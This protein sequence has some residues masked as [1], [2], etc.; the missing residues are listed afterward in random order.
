MVAHGADLGLS[1]AKT[2]RGHKSRLRN[3]VT[4]LPR[5]LFISIAFWILARECVQERQTCSVGSRPTGVKVR[6][7]LAWVV[8]VEKTKR[9]K[10][11]D[12]AILGMVSKA[13][14][15]NE[16]EPRSGLETK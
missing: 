2:S 15:R 14:G 5:M 10:P 9:M 12:K 8:S 4:E 1:F 6:S 3:N 16:S 11:T 7:P 13:P